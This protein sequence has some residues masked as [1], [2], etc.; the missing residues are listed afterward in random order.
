MELI[1]G[2]AFPQMAKTIRVRYIHVHEF[3]TD[4]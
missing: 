3:M 2:C 4:V 1:G